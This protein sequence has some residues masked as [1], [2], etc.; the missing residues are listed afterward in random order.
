MSNKNTFDGLRFRVMETLSA[1]K[2]VPLTALEITQRLHAGEFRGTLFDTLGLKVT[3]ALRT[4]KDKGE[5]LLADARDKEGRGTYQLPQRMLFPPPT[6]ATPANPVL[7]AAIAEKIVATPPKPKVTPSKHPVYAP[8]VQDEVLKFIKASP[9]PVVAPDVTAALKHI[10]PPEFSTER[11]SAILAGTIHALKKAGKIKT[12]RASRGRGLKYEYYV[13]KRQLD[14]VAPPAPLLEAINAAPK[15]VLMPSSAP[16]PK[17]ALFR[18][19]AP[20]QLEQVVLKLNYT[21][22]EMARVEAAAAKFG[23]PVDAFAKQAIDFAMA[24][25]D[26]QGDA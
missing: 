24:H 8:G 7:S 12:R 13:S 22:T 17:P 16:A 4:M 19:V 5:V 23:V 2:G 6:T 14:A 15:V 21:V 25:A 3:S 18:P 9:V 11:V 1:A 10:Y 20:V 26:S